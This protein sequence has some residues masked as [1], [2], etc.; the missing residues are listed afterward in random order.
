MGLVKSGKIN[1]YLKNVLSQFPASSVNVSGPTVTLEDN[2][3]AVKLLLPG[4]KQKL[5]R[6]FNIDF[7]ILKEY[8]SLN[9]M[10]IRQV[11][12]LDNPADFFTK[13][14]GGRLFEK[15][16]SYINGHGQL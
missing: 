13:L 15:H 10:K 8:V 12:S 5:S 4:G 14:L 2:E 9:E 6:H 1:I 16:K 11:P 3:A 7:H